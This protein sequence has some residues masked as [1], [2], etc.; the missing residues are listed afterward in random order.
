MR[1]KGL[2]N[3]IARASAKADDILA[4]EYVDSAHLDGNY[5]AASSTTTP[6]TETCPKK[7]HCGRKGK[8]VATGGGRRK[9]IEPTTSTTCKVP[10]S[11]AASPA[12]GVK[13]TARAPGGVRK[14]PAEG[15]AQVTEVVASRRHKKRAG[16]S[17][18]SEMADVEDKATS[19]TSTWGHARA[20]LVLRVEAV[21][22][23]L[24]WV[25][26]AKA[27][28]VTRALVFRPCEGRK[29]VSEASSR[30]PHAPALS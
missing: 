20:A 3:T 8:T 22:V 14:L 17:E 19:K 9:G 30:M 15:R 5:G 29:R 16:D 24:K 10:P 7:V 6:L 21:S 13:K 2:W 4:E 1:L 23:A 11:N 26:G 28:Q 27:I 12:A 25:A 18:K